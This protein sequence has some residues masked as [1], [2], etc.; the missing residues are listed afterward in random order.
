MPQN[1]TGELKSGAYIITSCAT[2]LPIARKFVEDKQIVEDLYT[3][4][5]P[6]P[7]RV[8]TLPEDSNDLAVRL[9]FDFETMY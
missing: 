7:I 2:N 6:K 1:T 8:V 9:D 4:T 3:Q 5:V